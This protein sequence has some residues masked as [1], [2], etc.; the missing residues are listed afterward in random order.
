[1]ATGGL[2]SLITNDGRQDQ[3]LMA[4]T[5]LQSRLSGN[6]ATPSLLKLEG[7]KHISL[8]ELEHS[9]EQIAIIIEKLKTDNECSIC[10]EEMDI[11]SDS[12]L[13]LTECEHIFHSSC[14]E[15][16]HKHKYN[17]PLCRSAI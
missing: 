11:D 8:F 14:I 17:C 2:F 10:K 16:W 3:M 4:S 6:G 1:M 15:S 9:E 12:K 13:F 5:F 7:F